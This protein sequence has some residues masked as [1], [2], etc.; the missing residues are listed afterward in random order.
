MEREQSLISR[1]P[2]AEFFSQ[3]QTPTGPP[4]PRPVWEPQAR[5]CIGSRLSFIRGSVPRQGERCGAP[6]AF[7]SLGGR[8][9]PGRQV[10]LWGRLSPQDRRGNG[11]GSR[12]G[13]NPLRPE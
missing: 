2:P 5:V 11:W 9:R 4:S 8:P 12:D 3:K 7:G 1:L 10:A 6:A 13:L